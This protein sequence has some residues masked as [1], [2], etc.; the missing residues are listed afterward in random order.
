MGCLKSH[1]KWDRHRLFFMFVKRLNQRWGRFLPRMPQCRCLFLGHQT[2]EVK[3]LESTWH[4]FRRNQLL[5]ITFGQ[6]D[7]PGFISF[8]I[9]FV[10]LVT[11]ISFFVLSFG[12]IFN[13]IKVLNFSWFYLLYSIKI[14]IFDIII[15]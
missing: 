1:K 8:V 7:K 11:T 4:C 12:N 13:I 3:L 14:I 6:K 5:I 15:K 9:A 10:G 2:C